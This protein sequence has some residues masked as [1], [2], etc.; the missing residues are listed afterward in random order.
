MKKI[1]DIKYEN[2]ISVQNL[3]KAWNE[4][5]L[6]KKN[7][8]DACDFSRNLMDN[9][10]DLHEDLKNK[11]YKH[12]GYKA[13]NISDPKPRNIHKASVRDRLLHRAI[14]RILYPLFD[15]TFFSESY[16]CRLKKGTL[17]A[18][19]K[20]R[21]FAFKESKNHYR[22]FWV[23][24]CDIKKFFASINHQI[25]IKILEERINDKN[26]IWLL[27]QI[28]R[29]FH[30]TQNGVG[31]PLGN[32]TSQLLV[33]VYMN[34]FDS[35]LKHRLKIRYYIR[36]ADDLVVLSQDKNY[37]R[38]LI[39]QIADFLKKELVLQLHP[40]K[41]FIKNFSFGVDFL[42]WIH[43]PN[44]RILR[45]STKKRVLKALNESMNV[46]SLV[47]YYGLLKHGN[48]FE[49]R[50]KIKEKIKKLKEMEKLKRENLMNFK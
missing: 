29:S 36:Y 5:L 46:S 45:T 31:L 40:N 25:L 14:Y 39:P 17:R 30:S 10:L 12:G 38:K 20:F 24:K 27:S 50:I 47:S 44:F 16:S 33:N 13:F 7:K 11:T 34:N 26:I 37:L 4:F 9:I 19:N 28:I 18:I 43:F 49:I 21:S 15:K 1:F 3:L 48:Q 6:G 41:L 2:I 8:E 22:I 23:L 32:L 35:F 42:G